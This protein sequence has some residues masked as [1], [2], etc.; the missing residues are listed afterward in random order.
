MTDFFEITQLEGE[1]NPD[2][3]LNKAKRIVVEQ[4][5]KHQ[6]GLGPI[7]ADDVYIVTFT[8]TLG[9]F[10]AQ[11]GVDKPDLMY[12]EVT[13]NASKK[14]TYLDAY[15]KLINIEIAD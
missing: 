1:S 4:V 2:R 14:V 6:L 15:K 3:F 8:Y 7:T 11:L 5:N 12:Y 13:Y 9:N 10:K